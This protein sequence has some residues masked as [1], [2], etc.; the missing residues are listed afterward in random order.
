MFTY[1]SVQHNPTLLFNYICKND[2]V[3][4][5]QRA[6][7]TQCQVWALFFLVKGQDVKALIVRNNKSVTTV[8]QKCWFAFIFKTSDTTLNP[9]LSC[10][11]IR[12]KSSH[13]LSFSSSVFTWFS[14]QLSPFRT[15]SLELL[16]PT[17]APSIQVICLNLPV[18]LISENSLALNSGK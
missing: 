12:F 16:F 7:S 17:D 6:M 18:P 15:S 8:L 2:D 13:H 11:S 10:S 14:P 1:I 9:L 5:Q 3:Q 4:P